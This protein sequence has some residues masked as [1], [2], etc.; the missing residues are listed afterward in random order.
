MPSAACGLLAALSNAQGRGT[1]RFGCL[2]RQAGQ[3]GS[4][5]GHSASP[6][7]RKAATSQGP[8]PRQRTMTAVT[9]RQ[10]GGMPL[11]QAESRHSRGDAPRSLCEAR[12]RAAGACI[13]MPCA[14]TEWSGGQGKGTCPLDPMRE[15]RLRQQHL[16][17]SDARSLANR[18]DA[19][20]L[21]DRA[22]PS[23]RRPERRRIQMTVLFD[24]PSQL[25]KLG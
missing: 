12:R 19:Q 8:S 16:R 25:K 4:L 11:R 23:E 14:A 7:T 2:A 20:P 24:R 22:D 13:R 15:W 18:L 6:V 1:W 9:P 21:A 10:A 3:I 17:G 5:L